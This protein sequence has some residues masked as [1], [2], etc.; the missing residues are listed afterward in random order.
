MVLSTTHHFDRTRRQSALP[1]AGSLTA[2]PLAVANGDGAPANASASLTL[3]LTVRNV[4]FEFTQFWRR[5]ARFTPGAASSTGE[6]TSN[7]LFVE[8]LRTYPPGVITESYSFGHSLEACR[9]DGVGLSSKG[10]EASCL[11]PYR[12]L[13]VSPWSSLQHPLSGVLA[14]SSP[15]DTGTLGKPAAPLDRRVRLPEAADRRTERRRAR[16][17]VVRNP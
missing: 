3:R 13:R 4:R 12:I 16:V 11:P 17:V 9:F 7:V 15:R 8:R 5:F 2:E 1:R 6:M 10:L 14:A